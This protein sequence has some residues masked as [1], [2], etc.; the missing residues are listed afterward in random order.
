[1]SKRSSTSD[2]TAQGGRRGLQGRTYPFIWHWLMALLVVPLVGTIL[3]A[4]G[5]RDATIRALIVFV[6]WP[7]FG[8]L[9]WFAVRLGQHAGRKPIIYWHTAVS[10]AAV[11]FSWGLTTVTGWSAGWAVV[12]LFASVLFAASWN[13]HR[14]DALRSRADEKTPEDKGWAEVLGIPRSKVGRPTVTANTISATVTAGPG[15][16]IADAQGAIP[17][18]EAAAH[19]TPG[20]TRIVQDPDDAQVGELVIA[21][22]DALRTWTSWPGP[23][24]VGGSIADPICTAVYEDGTP[25]RY[26]FCAGVTD[27]GDPRV[28]T[29]MGRM[30]MSGSGKTGDA[31]LEL[32][33]LMTRRDVVVLY[34]DATKGAQTS[35]PLMRGIALYADTGPKGK[36]LFRGVQRMIRDR[37]DRLGHAGFADWSPAC[38]E[39]ELRMPAVVYFVDEADELINHQLFEWLCGKARSAGVFLSVALP[40][41]DNTSMPTKARFNI[42]A[43]KCYGCGDDYSAEFALTEST[44]KAGAHP[45]NW[46]AS[47]PGYHYLDTANGV[48]PRLF[49]V[50][51]RTYRHSDLQIE[52]AVR[53]GDPYRAVLPGYD[54]TALGEA[55]KY[56]QPGDAR[57]P[58]DAVQPGANDDDGDDDGWDADVDEEDDVDGTARVLARS[59]DAEDG[60]RQVYAA[61]DPRTPIPPYRGPDVQFGDDSPEPVSQA[62]A[63]AEFDRVLVTMCAEPGRTVVTTAEMTER[64]TLRSSTWRSR[65]LMGVADGD[66][67]SPP[68]LT[69]IRDEHRAGVY[70]IHRLNEH[71][72]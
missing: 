64:Y 30:G 25:Q 10:V 28:G 33:E 55:W 23:S 11:G 22:Q 21:R 39:H 62:E 20:R 9:G 26:W 63:E 42:G 59:D 44:R 1:M 65:R 49:P 48:D 15:E 56:C 31:K 61:V 4:V 29:H 53:G 27:D 17:K 70:H 38:Y 46:R 24:A 67:V 41:A 66:V 47:K 34:A 71:G 5:L 43:W 60:D 51:C 35:K 12:H 69:L 19:G 57:R 3:W 32:A 40:R 6:D 16:T 18:I 36:I 68:G 72:Q 37:A 14:V 13:L 45:E 52:A 7:T 8:L 50:P 58:G 2:D 54:I